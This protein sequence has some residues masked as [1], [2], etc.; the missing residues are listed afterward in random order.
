MTG[1]NL[2]PPQTSDSSDTIALLL[3]IIFGVFGLLGMG[4][5]YA[6]NL[7]VA[8]GLFVG[9]LIVVFIEMFIAT[10]T[11]GFAACLILPFNLAVAIVS[12]FKARDY[13][14]NSGAKGSVLYVILALVIG[15]VVIC[16]GLFMFFGGLGFLSSQ[17][18][19]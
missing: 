13:V 10:F 11:L 6:G 18:P 14:R 1:Q 9:F 2:N 15:T 5:L 4:W 16:G 19:F 8:I 3:E 17:S 12:G 7:P